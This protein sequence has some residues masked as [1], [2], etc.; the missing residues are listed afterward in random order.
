MTP[1]LSWIASLHQPRGGSLLWHMGGLERVLGLAAA[2]V[3]AG[4]WAVTLLSI[5]DHRFRLPVMGLSLLLEVFGWG[6]VLTRGRLEGIRHARPRST[7]T[8]NEP[9]VLSR[10]QAPKAGAALSRSAKRKR[11]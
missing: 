2:A 4:S 3:I 7:S 10:N 8:R 1:T 6:V 9:A 11:R 5:G